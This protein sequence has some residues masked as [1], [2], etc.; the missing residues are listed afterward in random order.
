MLLLDPTSDT[1]LVT[2]IVDGIAQ[3][4]DEQRLR[5]GAKLPSIRK[6]AQA[7]GV[8]H[9]TVVEAYDR[10]VARG[11][12][13]AVPNAGFY[14]RGPAVEDSAGDE[15]PTE[16]DLDAHLLLHKVFQPL[17]MEIRPGVGLLPEH[18]LDGEG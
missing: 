14:V 2:Q 12:L 9:F 4:I 11:C 6:F 18:W 7:N 10:L 1:P 17:G 13:N 16:F 3:A 8:S 15:A 5:S